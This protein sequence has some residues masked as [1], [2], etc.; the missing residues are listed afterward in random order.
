MWPDL[1]FFFSPNASFVN[2]RLSE[3][4]KSKNSPTLTFWCDL[5]P[6]AAGRYFLW[7]LVTVMLVQRAWQDAF[8]W[9]LLILLLSS[10][11]YPL[12]SACAHTFS[13]MSPRARHICF[14]FDYGAV[15]FYALGEHWALLAGASI[16][17][18]IIMT[19]MLVSVL[20]EIRVMKLML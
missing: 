19:P 16:Q 10:C 2:A 8:S 3:K 14:F 11:M 1:K 12:A 4:S 20:V 7:K 18:S 5:C 13:S 9:P 17:I 15:S 6:A